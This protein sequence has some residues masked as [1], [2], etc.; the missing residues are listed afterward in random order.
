MLSLTCAILIYAAHITV[1]FFL[2]L[3][4]LLP[5]PGLCGITPILPLDAVCGA[6]LTPT[7]AGSPTHGVYGPADVATN[8]EKI[9]HISATWMLSVYLF[10]FFYYHLFFL[11]NFLLSIVF[12][13]YLYKQRL[14]IAL[15]VHM[16]I[17]CTH[18]LY[19]HMWCH[20]RM[21]LLHCMLYHTQRKTYPYMLYHTQHP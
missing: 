12:F 20:S 2:A 18:V 17:I 6:A 5:S 15:C 10:F 13:K 1:I 14:F 4:F 3:S 7:S 11:S 8:A 16:F 19:I 9:V 21:A